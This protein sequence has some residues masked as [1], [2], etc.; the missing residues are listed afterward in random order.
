MSDSRRYVGGF[1]IEEQ[2]RLRAEL[3]SLRITN[4]KLVE[5][6][7]VAKYDYAEALRIA[8][9]VTPSPELDTVRVQRATLLEIA[10]RMDSM[11]YSENTSAFDQYIKEIRALSDR[12]GA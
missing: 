6:L 9:S 11:A 4:E 8:A 7:G 12:G 3:A 5:A 10:D 1:D 2:A